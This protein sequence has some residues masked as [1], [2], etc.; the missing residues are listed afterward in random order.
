[1]GILGSWVPGSMN[2]SNFMSSLFYTSRKFTF[3]IFFT[4]ETKMG[5]GLS[6][7]ERGKA[8]EDLEDLLIAIVKIDLNQQ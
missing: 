3:P 1:M 4:L 5:E 7:T 8:T 6:H 2:N